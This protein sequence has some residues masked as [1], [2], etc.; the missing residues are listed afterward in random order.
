MLYKKQL[1]KIRL[2]RYAVAIPIITAFVLLLQ[3]ETTA[4]VRPQTSNF[5]TSDTGGAVSYP[6]VV[7]MDVNKNITDKEMKEKKVLYKNVFNAD[8]SFDDI[9][10]NTRGEITAITI[11]IKD[12]DNQTSYPV[13]EVIMDNSEGITPFTMGIERVSAESKNDIFFGKAAQKIVYVGDDNTNDVTYAENTEA[14]S[15]AERYITER[16]NG[17]DVLLVI[18][19]KIQKGNKLALPHSEKI[20]A[21]SEIDAESTYKKYNVSAKDGAIEIATVPVKEDYKRTVY[22]NKEKISKKSE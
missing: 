4:Q 2:R 12:D 18:N 21:M 11:R 3:V 1:K 10:R 22:K 15:E 14:P 7:V 19:G 20:T 6:I 9:K 5:I 17:R 13:R 16:M 8:V